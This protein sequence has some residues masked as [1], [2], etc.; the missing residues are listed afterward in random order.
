MVAVVVVSPRLLEM[1]FVAETVIV[2]GHFETVVHTAVAVAV[3]VEMN[4]VDG[5]LQVAQHL[6]LACPC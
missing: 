1:D 3:A 2:R 4:A 6:S 5:M